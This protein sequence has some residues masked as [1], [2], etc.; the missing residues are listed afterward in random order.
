MDDTFDDLLLANQRYATSA[1][2]NFDGYAHAGIAV[3]TCMDS[4]LQP[5]EMIGLFLGEA[6]ILRTPGG[7]VTEDAMNGCI[8]GVNLLRVRRILVVSHSKCA[9]ASGDD[10]ELSRRVSQAS[11]RDASGLEFGA[12]PDQTGRLR[13]DV[14]LLAGHP[15]IAGRASVGGFHYDVDTGLLQRIC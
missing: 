9:M 7:H 3:V 6:K 11:G 13:A 14:K 8:L 12:D 4:R 5:L 15:L 2:R 1:P 10:E